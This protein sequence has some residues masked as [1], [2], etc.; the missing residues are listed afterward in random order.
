[1]AIWGQLLCVSVGS[2]LG[3]LARWGSGL[4]LARVLGT[5]FPWGTFLINIS[6]S[7]FLGWFATVLSQRYLRGAETWVS[8][9]HLRLLVGVGFT[10]AFTTFSTFEWEADQLLR[11]DQG[12]RSFVYLVGSVALGLLAVRLGVALGKAL[13]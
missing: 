11:H 12:V 2:A 9:D 10:G 4:A 3:G 6:G 5:A 1:M 8:A 13:E 7:F